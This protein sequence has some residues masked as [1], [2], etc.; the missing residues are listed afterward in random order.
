M[1]LAVI[2]NGAM[3]LPGGIVL[4]GVCGEFELV[5]SL[6]SFGLPRPNVLCLR[7]VLSRGS[8]VFGFAAWSNPSALFL[9]KIRDRFTYHIS[10]LIS[11]IRDRFGMVRARCC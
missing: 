2:V 9:V 5:R 10:M 1:F 3:L 8:G 7:V 11:S 6:I 4:V